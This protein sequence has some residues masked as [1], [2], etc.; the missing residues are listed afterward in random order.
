[1][2]EQECFPHFR[3]HAGGVNDWF[4]NACAGDLVPDL[5]LDHLSIQLPC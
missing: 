2:R 1:M 5:R 4:T 3:A